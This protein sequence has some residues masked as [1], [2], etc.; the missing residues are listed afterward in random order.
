MLGDIAFE[1]GLAVRHI[2]VNIYKT[3]LIRSFIVLH[4][5][6]SHQEQ[7]L[8]LF[9]VCIFFNPILISFNFLLATSQTALIL[10]NAVACFPSP[11]LTFQRINIVE[12]STSS[13]FM[14]VYMRWFRVI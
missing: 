5:P 11:D 8:F 4:R 9:G 13:N 10:V 3:T 7:F 1:N 6:F 12:L 2:V 14:P